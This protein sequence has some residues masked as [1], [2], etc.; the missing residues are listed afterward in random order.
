[1]FAIFSPG[2][3]ELAIIAIVAVLLFGS[4]LP[5][6]ARSI[7]AAIPEFKKGIRGLEDEKNEIEKAIK[8]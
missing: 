8:E 7:G 2:P 3:M 5:K 6:V 1:M 4:Q